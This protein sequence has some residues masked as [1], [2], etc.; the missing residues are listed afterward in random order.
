[1]SVSTCV[2]NATIIVQ[3]FLENFAVHFSS[4]MYRKLEEMPI[5]NMTTN[6]R[7]SMCSLSIAWMCNLP[8]VCNYSLSIY[9]SICS[10]LARMS[11]MSR[12]NSIWVCQD[13][14]TLSTAL[15]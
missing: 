14:K 9:S 10:L 11:C 7:V 3:Y 6:V 4:G 2:R 5:P 12:T 13:K 1:M 15:Q 8:V